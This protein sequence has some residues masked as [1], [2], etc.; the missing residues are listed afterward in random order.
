M[1]CARYDNKVT[2]T[3]ENRCQS[4]PSALRSSFKIICINAG[5][6]REVIDLWQDHV[7]HRPTAGD[8]Y[9]KLTDEKSQEFM[10]KV[11]F[12]NGKPAADLATRSKA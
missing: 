5:I 10:K 3:K 4:R 7:S 2:S 6:P 11:L 1:P 9:Y 12:G 8:G